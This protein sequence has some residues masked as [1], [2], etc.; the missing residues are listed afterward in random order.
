MGA[1]WQ[2]ARRLKFLHDKAPVY[3]PCTKDP[4]LLK[5]FDGGLEMAA[6][7]APDMS[8]LD[9]AVCK[10]MENAVERSGAMTPAEIRK[11]VKKAWKEKI[12]P[13]YLLKISKKV[14]SNMLKVIDLK[15]GNF[16]KD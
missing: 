5:L 10:I 15:G 1:R 16:Y 12:T 9:A 13:A 8:H 11:A 14:R 6:G 2:D 4:E 3:G 7:K